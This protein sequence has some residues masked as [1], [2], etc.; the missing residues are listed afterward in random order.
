MKYPTS[1]PLATVNDAEWQL[2]EQARLNLSGADGTTDDLA[3]YRAID[4]VLR[5]APASSL[6]DDFAESVARLAV[7]QVAS[8][9]DGFERN[10]IRILVAGLGISGGVA[11]AVYAG[12][13]LQAA[14]ASL[15]GL[16]DAP[17]GWTVAAL[18]CLGAS[19]LCSFLLREDHS[20]VNR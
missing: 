1:R 14:T 5:T 9:S 3:A 13:L 18:G 12:D 20:A 15:A 19:W 17:L 2:Q 8:R 4:R 11:M 6:P 7:Q 10:L 16:G